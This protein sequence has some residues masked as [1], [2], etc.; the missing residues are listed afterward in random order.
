[1]ESVFYPQRAWIGLFTEMPDDNG[2]NFR[3]VVADEYTRLDLHRGIY[4]EQSIIRVN[5][6]E[7]HF[8]E[9]LI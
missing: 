6:I 8:A 1:M 7:Q 5:L 2:K 4:S 3:E 9:L